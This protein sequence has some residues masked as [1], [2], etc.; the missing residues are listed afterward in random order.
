M[1]TLDIEGFRDYQQKRIEPYLLGLYDGE[2]FTY[3][4][5]SF[6][7]RDFINKEL[8]KKNRGTTYYVHYG[9]IFDFNLLLEELNKKE[10]RI[11]PISQGSKIIKMKITDSGDRNW[12]VQDTSSLLS[13]GLDALTKAF[14]VQHKKIEIIKKDNNYDHNLYMLY[15]KKPDQVLEYLKHDCMGLYEVLSSFKNIIENLNGKM[16][17]T[18]ASTAMRSFKNGYC[19]DFPKMEYRSINDEMRQAYFGGRTE[20]FRMHAKELIDD[21]YYYY[22]INSLYPYVMMHN[23]FPCSRP[24]I[25]RYPSKQDIFENVGITKAKITIPGSE[26]LPCIPSKIKSGYN[27]K[28]MFTVGIS[29]GYLDNSILKMGYEQGYT[30]EPIKS[31][32]FRSSDLFSDYVKTF[33]D[34]KKRQKNG[35]PMYLI[36]KLLLNSLY[37][38]FGQRQDSEMVIKD[39]FPNKKKYAFKDYVDFQTGWVRVSQEGKGK[40]YLPHIAIHVTALAQLELYKTMKEIYDKG[41]H[42]YYCDTDSITTDY[43][44]LPVSDRIGDWKLEKRLLSGEFILPKTYHTVNDDHVEEMRVKGYNKTLREKIDKNAFRNAIIDDDY[45]GFTVESDNDQLLRLRDSYNRFRSFNRLDTIRKSIKTRYNKRKIL[46]NLDTRPF[47]IKEIA[48]I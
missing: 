13:F 35:T 37:G 34:I 4:K 43:R 7:I 46:A 29:C 42:L 36:A 15:K 33:Y 8:T 12:Y 44:N 19:K 11:Y 24:T 16:G 45:E 40:H 41:Y 22:D 21:Y 17:L 1:V 18:I 2:T 47:D 48:N 26:Y 38:K 20:I 6:C 32:F 39:P 5:G 25:M 31:F 30:I 14:D 28:L 3:Y 27:K 10:Y 23:E 9:S